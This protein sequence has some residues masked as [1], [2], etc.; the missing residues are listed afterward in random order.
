[1]KILNYFIF[2]IICSVFINSSLYSYTI[3]DLQNKRKQLNTEGITYSVSVDNEDHAI[4]EAKCIITE[5]GKNK[6]FEIFNPY[7]TVNYLLCD[8]KLYQIPFLTAGTHLYSLKVIIFPEE[9]KKNILKEYNYEIP[10]Y[11]DCTLGND[12]TVNGY[13]CKILIKAV[14]ETIKENEKNFTTRQDITRMYVTE[15]YGYPTR[16]EYLYKNSYSNSTDCDEGFSKATVNFT[17]FNTDIA[18]KTIELPENSFIV[19]YKSN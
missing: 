18:N 5:K 9:I 2:C 8:D 10:D 14:T 1:M 15:T 6:F 19:D 16:I 3:E 4:S 7:T 11:T 12:I 17:N 13:Q